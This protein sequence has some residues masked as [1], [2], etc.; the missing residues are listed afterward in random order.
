MP[1]LDEKVLLEEAKRY[2][3]EQNKKTEVVE[4]RVYGS[5]KAW[6]GADGLLYPNYGEALQSIQAKKE[7]AKFKQLGLNESGQTPGQA[8][9]A[10]KREE[11]LKKREEKMNEVRDIETV[12]RNLRE[13][14]FAGLQNEEPK[15]EKKK[16]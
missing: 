12:I 3:E 14:D 2:E 4:E 9:L 10:K 15:K 1:E 6:V 5:R 13:E 8:A 7:R 11:L 16:K